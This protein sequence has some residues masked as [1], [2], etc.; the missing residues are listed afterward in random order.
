[1]DEVLSL[2]RRVRPWRALTDSQMQDVVVPFVKEHADKT[3]LAERRRNGAENLLV[4][5][6]HSPICRA[7]HPDLMCAT[8]LVVAGSTAVSA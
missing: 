7:Y 5:R 8:T 6:S 3:T 1:M 4:S 2:V